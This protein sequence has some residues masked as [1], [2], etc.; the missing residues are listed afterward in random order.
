MRAWRDVLVGEIVV[1][2]PAIEMSK[3]SKGELRNLVKR[4]QAVYASGNICCAGVSAGKGNVVHRDT[5]GGV[6]DGGG[7]GSFDSCDRHAKRDI[8]DHGKEMGGRGR[9]WGGLGIGTETAGG[10]GCGTHKHRAGAGSNWMC[11]DGHTGVAEMPFDAVE[12]VRTHGSRFSF[13]AATRK[14]SWTVFGEPGEISLVCVRVWKIPRSE[15]TLTRI[16]VLTPTRSTRRV[17]G[18]RAMNDE[19]PLVLELASLRQTA[20]RF[21][22]SGTFS[23]IAI[24]PIHTSRVARGSVCSSP[25]AAPGT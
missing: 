22:V 10:R 5:G 9:S 24:H 3:D 16:Y 13:L 8:H 7:D 2:V 18:E 11:Q 25:T 12:G 19:H 1:V 6:V 4:E 21:E 17:R 14:N 15:R 23:A 20:V